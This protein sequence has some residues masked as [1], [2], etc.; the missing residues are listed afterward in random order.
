M[1]QVP[2]PDNPANWSNEQLRG[3]IPKLIFQTK[4]DFELF[5]PFES[6][7]QILRL[8]E[9]EFIERAMLACPVLSEK[10]ALKFHKS[11][12]KLLIDARTKDRKAKM[13]SKMASTRKRELKQARETVRVHI[14]E[15]KKLENRG[16]NANT[17]TVKENEN[18]G[19]DCLKNRF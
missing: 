13:K 15:Y 7:M 19:D 9:A 6:G 12:W 17:G 14:A 3:F 2:N 5:C 18:P 1:F 16:T 11:L 8:P 4:I 10:S